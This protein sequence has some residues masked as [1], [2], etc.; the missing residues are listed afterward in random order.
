MILSIKKNLMMIGMALA[1]FFMILARAFTL[2]KKVEQQKQTEKAL[3]SATTRLEVENEIN[4]KSD[5]DVRA[6]LS[7][8][9]RD[10]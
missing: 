1:A 6:E 9:V 8:W 5:A 3:Q 10:K 4:K 7:E 2:G